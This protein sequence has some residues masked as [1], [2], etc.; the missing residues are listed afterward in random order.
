[1]GLSFGSF[2]WLEFKFCFVF[3]TEKVVTESSVLTILVHL[4]CDWLNRRDRASAAT[5]FPSMY[6]RLEVSPAQT[7]PIWLVFLEDFFQNQGVSKDSDL[8]KFK[9]LILVSMMPMFLDHTLLLVAPFHVWSSLVLHHSFFWNKRVLFYYPFHRFVSVQLQH[10]LLTYQ[11]IPPLVEKYEHIAKLLNEKIF[12]STAQKF[13]IPFLSIANDCSFSLNL[14]EVLQ[15]LQ[16]C[17]VI[18]R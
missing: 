9:F 15:V 2:S 14:F 4:W 17:S 1:M 13:F 6:F 11:P 18:L 8:L 16:K 7:R 5:F 3:L 12:F 10:S